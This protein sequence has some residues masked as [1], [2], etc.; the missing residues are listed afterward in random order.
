MEEIGSVIKDELY[1]IRP[2][3]YCLM[4][5][6]YGAI[7]GSG[8]VSLLHSGYEVSF[9]HEDKR[10]IDLLCDVVYRLTGRE[11]SIEK[12]NIDGMDKYV[13]YMEN[14]VSNELLERCFII[15]DRY[16]IIQGIPDRLFG[17]KGKGT[18]EEDDLFS[19][20]YSEARRAFLRG[21]YLSCGV[22]RVP[23]DI[24]EWNQEKTKSG[25]MLSF[26][27]NAGYVREDVITILSE[28]GEV[29]RSSVLVRLRGSGVF[30]K[31]SQAICNVLTAIGSNI[32]VLQLYEIITN[33]KM[34]N[35]MNRMQNFEIA[36]I[37]KTV[38][39]SS[40]Q[41]MAIKRLDKKMGIKNLPDGLRKV[42][43]L[44]LANEEAGLEE[45]AKMFNPPITKSCV[46]H[47][48]RRIM[49]LSEE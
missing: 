7:R 27:L 34:K 49:Q 20:R 48:M 16:T 11:S 28:E 6:L 2:E 39:S 24:E 23:D 19:Q 5:F 10:F 17:E 38:R 36:N 26:N 8:D 40:R 47:R 15:K 44:R 29:D 9:V 42:C 12:T 21:L 4:P 30:I 43:E 18:R 35:D 1:A 13:L 32:G 31:N 46:N 41:V 25:Y 33:R 37:D 22:L 14:D 45:I 3:D